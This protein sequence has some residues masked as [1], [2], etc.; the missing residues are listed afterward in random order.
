MEGE[1]AYEVDLKLRDRAARL[2]SKLKVALSQQDRQTLKPD[3]LH[4]NLRRGVSGGGQRK[5]PEIQEF[6]DLLT[7]AGGK[8][9]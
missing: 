6:G 8:R 9:K 2:C 5:S 4:L 3:Y 7:Q 1:A